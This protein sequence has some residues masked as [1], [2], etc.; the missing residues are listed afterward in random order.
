MFVLRIALTKKLR[1]LRMASGGCDRPD[2]QLHV[3]T[4]KKAAVRNRSLLA[5]LYIRLIF[6]RSDAPFC[7]PALRRRNCCQVA[8]PVPSLSPDEFRRR[9]ADGRE[10]AVP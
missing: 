10:H 2:F 6:S 3:Q 1:C 9:S 8:F 5:N 7:D 4:T